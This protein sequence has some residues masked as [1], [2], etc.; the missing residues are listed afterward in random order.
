MVGLSGGY[1]CRLIVYVFLSEYFSGGRQ[2]QPF[3][4]QSRLAPHCVLVI[5]SVNVLCTIKQK[6]PASLLQIFD[7]A[8]TAL[9][10]RKY[11]FY[12]SAAIILKMQQKYANRIFN[13][14]K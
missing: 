1:F 8:V 11:P 9:I 5:A 13:D 12:D 3:T 4:Q 6:H 10:I 14:K 2:R 7:A